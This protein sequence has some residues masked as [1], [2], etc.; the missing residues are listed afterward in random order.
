MGIAKIS[1][2]FS[3]LSLILIGFGA[4]VG[5]F[6]G[7]IL[8]WMSIFFFIALGMNI[9]SYVKSDSI[10]IKMTRSKIIEKSDNPRFYDIVEKVSRQ[11]GIPIPRVG[12][13]PTDVP[14]AFATGK[15]ENHA[16]VVAT[17]GILQMLND[18]E[19]EAVIGHEISHIT[20]KDI[21]I[22]SIAATIATLISY[23]GNVIIFSEFFGGIGERNSN[24]GII[25]L[26]AAIL[27]PVG[28]MFVQLGISR[29][30]EAYADEGSVRLLKKPDELI[31]SLKKISNV[32]IARR[33]PILNRNTRKNPQ[34]GAY[35]SLFIV[36]NFSTHTLTNLFSTHP[37]LEKRIENINRVRSELNI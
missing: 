31:S 19:L 18:D 35:S 27:I 34:P 6:L 2:L 33:K 16:V 14:N 3:T 30:R 13:M 5:Y 15:D 20:H 8:L 32:K 26:I 21:L 11:A 29:D 24:S 25:L 9:F 12:I 37:S 4:L 28:A 22:S 1:I 10:A 23:I 36:N 7:G 17:S